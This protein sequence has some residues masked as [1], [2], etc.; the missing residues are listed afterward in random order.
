M[1]LLRYQYTNQIKSCGLELDA[2]GMLIS[3][4]EYYL[5]Q[6]QKFLISCF[7]HPDR[8]G[9]TDGNTSY[10]AGRNTTEVQNKRYRYVGKERDEETG[11]YYMG[12]RYYSP[13]L[14]R[15]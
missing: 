6:K 7:L 9:G 8:I 12:A 15:W 10:Q 3:F 2:D 4:E 1:Q 11:L 13:W 14:C 5:L